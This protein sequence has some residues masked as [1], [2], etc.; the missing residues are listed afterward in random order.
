ML[1]S[2]KNNTRSLYFSERITGMMEAINDY[3]LTIVEAPMGYGKTTAVKE[4]LNKSGVNVQWQQI[5]NDD[6]NEFWKGFCTLISSLNMEIGEGLI[7]LGFP[8]DSVSVQEAFRIL[9]D[10]NLEETTTLVLDDYH[11]VHD[12]EVDQFLQFLVM[13]EL[14]H[15]HIVL[16]TRF[17]KFM[18]ME[19]LQLKGF[20]HY[21]AKENLIL[22]PDGIKKYYKLCGIN[23]T[24]SD[25]DKLFAYTEGWIGA[26]YL[27]M[28][29]YNNDGIFERA[30]NIYK[31]VEK[32]IYEPFS[33]EIKE[34][35]LKMSLFDSFTMEQANHMWQKDNAPALL[36][37][38]MNKNALVRY[39]MQNKTYQFHNIFT[40][41]LRDELAKKSQEYKKQL[42]LHSAR[43]Y[44]KERDFLAA[45]NGFY[46]ADEFDALLNV[47]EVDKGHCIHN[48][49]KD[50]FI[51]YFEN[52]PDAIKQKHPIA[53]LIY[54]LCLFTF[55]EIERFE[56]VCGEFSASI[57]QNDSLSESEINTLMGEFE[58]L[59][60][61]TCYNDILGM[62][63]HINR[64]NTLLDHATQFIDTK[65]GFTFGAPSILYMFHREIGTLE[66]NVEILKEALPAYSHVTNGHAT[67]GDFVMEAE[68]YFNRG[69]LEN[70][71]IVA[72]KALYLANKYDQDEITICAMFLQARIALHKGDY[73]FVLY[74]LQKLHE[75][76]KQKKWYHL[77]HMIDLCEAFVNCNIKRSDKIPAWVSN[78]DFDSSRLYFPAIS[79]FNIVY[80]RAM[81][82]NQEYYKLLGLEEYLIGMASIFPNLL[83]QIYATI[84]LSAANAGIYR[85]E[86]ALSLLKKALELAIPDN[87]YMPFVENVDYIGSMLNELLVQQQYRND[88]LQ[89][90]ELSSKYQSSLEHIRKNYFTEKKL[91][92]ADRE[93]EIAKLAAE[94]Y[95]NREIAEQ[96]LIT[97]NTVKTLLKRVFEKLDI[98]SRA[99]LRQYF[100][101]K[102]I[103]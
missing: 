50:V 75:E 57:N 78:G 17:I 80:A 12:K 39:D 32:A 81:L 51:S 101:Q 42:T 63:K 47:V 68:W 74:V 97:Q 55:N 28:I 49:Q 87:I 60:S 65:G 90:L 13:E 41:F 43:W 30:D 35:L 82:T 76:M 85:K 88:I 98:N 40:K 2:S 16:I 38:I 19:E 52:C 64:A 94:G 18:N 84:Q 103:N 54:G 62:S 14:E 7:E 3:S 72:H 22:N 20:L 45:M 56:K 33:D 37:E 9:K 86:E 6:K 66:K 48:E 59:L 25:A 95:S 24:D 26:L 70:A 83:G 15:L 67:G 8:K 58:L 79:F 61:F 44:V 89:I 10:L 100:N 21:I 99:L 29:H 92:L 5:E 36:E 69:D 34:F 73:D 93:L 96:L 53:L 23:L 91:E 31:L 77:M 4:L 1:K 102:I 46:R 71:E 27:L 11:L